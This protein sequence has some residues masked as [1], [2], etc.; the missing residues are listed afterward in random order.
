MKI[1]N[2]GRSIYEVAKV[3][4]SETYEVVLRHD[5]GDP[6]SF[7]QRNRKVKFLAVADHISDRIPNHDRNDWICRFVAPYPRIRKAG[8]HGHARRRKTSQSG[9]YFTPGQPEGFTMAFL[10]TNTVLTNILGNCRR[11]RH[12][13]NLSAQHREHH[14]EVPRRCRHGRA[15]RGS[16]SLFYVIF[17]FLNR[18]LFHSVGQVPSCLARC[19][20]KVVREYGSGVLLCACW[21]KWNNAHSF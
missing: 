1:Q 12:P 11:D 21:K 15:G 19:R 5:K 10:E 7:A 2:H 18:L 13:G 4:P 3:F 8:M 9:I 16:E 20:R 6:R 14:D 17:T